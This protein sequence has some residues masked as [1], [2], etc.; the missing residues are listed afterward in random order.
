MQRDESSFVYAMH[1]FGESNEKW[2]VILTG[3]ANHNLLLI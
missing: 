3:Q 2:L 1:E